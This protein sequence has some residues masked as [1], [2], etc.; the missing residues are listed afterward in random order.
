MDLY[1]NINNY[2]VNRRFKRI[3]ICILLYIT[4]YSYIEY[5]INALLCMY[6]LC[7]YKFIN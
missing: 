1:I 5:L 7:N 2:I 4:I 3:H 6:M